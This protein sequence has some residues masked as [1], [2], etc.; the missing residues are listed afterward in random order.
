MKSL[1]DSDF[2]C[3]SAAIRLLPRGSIDL[4]PWLTGPLKEFFPYQRLI[5]A[6]GELVAGELDVTHML[7]V[8]H[9]ERYLSQ[10]PRKFELDCRSSLGWWFAQRRPFYIDPN[11]PPPHASKFEIEEINCFS[12]KNVAAHGVLNIKANA[13]TYFSFSGIEEPFSIW[14]L[15]ALELMAPV[16][17]DLFIIYCAGPPS[18]LADKISRLSFRQKEIARHVAAGLN[19]KQIGRALGISEKTIR[20]QLVEVYA[21]LGVGKRTQLMAILK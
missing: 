18:N 7:A 9:D 20:N 17:N 13:G 5:L 1:T 8:G 4:L 14:H 3:W 19:D 11:S 2:H 10:L 16:L 6:H 21:K 15:E 12:L